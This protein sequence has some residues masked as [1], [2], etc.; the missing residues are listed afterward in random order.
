MT[1]KFTIDPRS[2]GVLLSLKDLGTP[3]K[4]GIRQGFYFLGRDLRT[5]A[6]KNILKTPR[7]GAQRRKNG[8]SR[9]R[10]SVEGESFSNL[11]GAARRTLGFDVRGA[12]SLEFGFREGQRTRYT[13]ILEEK[14][15]RP[16]IE[17]AVK[18]NFR[19]MTEHLA[20]EMDK[21]IKDGFR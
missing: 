15:N 3:T 1:I 19:N 16:T 4:R 20:R 10:A 2:K 14:R 13:K 7:A 12:D 5:T 8:R 11:T 18:S 21:A 17:I 6:N 9:G